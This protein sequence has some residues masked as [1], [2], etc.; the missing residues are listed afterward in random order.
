M[1]L[2]PKKSTDFESIEKAPVNEVSVVEETSTDNL[3][4]NTTTVGNV[5]SD[6]LGDSYSAEFETPINGLS[7]EEI[8]DPNQIKITISNMRSPI[9]I[10]F[11]PGKCGKTMTQIRLARYLHEKGFRVCPV[12]DFRPAYDAN[13][14]KMCD[15]YPKFVNDV[16]AAAST[17]MLSFMLL[18][19]LDSRGNSICQILEAPGEHYHSIQNPQAE[20]PPYINELISNASRKIWIITLEPNWEPKANCQDYDISQYVE[21][22]KTLKKKINRRD[23]VVF[24]YNKIDA[25]NLMID[26]THVN[27]REMIYAIKE[28]FKGIFE[29]FKNENPITS[30]WR[31]YNCELL[32]FTTGSFNNYKM[33]VEERTTY[34]VGSDIFPAQLWQTIIKYTKG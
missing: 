12:R 17:D 6:S 27:R 33:G 29:P 15:D 30:L 34:T 18:E 19:V 9:V 24:L 28:H 22:I 16:N 5:D 23:N 14:K 8:R 3:S 31:K 32:P 25:T 10:L 1:E 7:Q 26:Q 11:G 20:F 21:K 2:N 4:N 13:Y